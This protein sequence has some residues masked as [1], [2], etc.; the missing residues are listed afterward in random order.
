M[1]VGT[2]ERHIQI[3]NLSNPTTP[4]KVRWLTFSFDTCCLHINRTKRP[5]NLLSNG[6]QELCRA[7]PLQTVLQLGVSK[8]EL[9]F[10]MYIIPTSTFSFPQSLR[11][12]RYVEE[13]DSQYVLTPATRTY[14]YSPPPGT[15]STSS[16]TDA[17]KRRMQKTNLWFSL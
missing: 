10:S 14:E 16:A 11:F 17:I 1:V 12:D 3:Y 13:K 9:Q 4:F 2:A 7:S 5:C 8:G 15:T 6:K